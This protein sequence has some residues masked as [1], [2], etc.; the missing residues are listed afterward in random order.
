MNLLFWHPG[1][2]HVGDYFRCIQF[3]KYL[4]NRGHKVTCLLGR[5]KLSQWFGRETIDS[6]EFVYA[7]HWAELHVAESFIDAQPETKMPLDILCRTVWTLVNARHYDIVHSFHVGLSSLLPLVTA[8][9]F[10]RT[11][12]VQDWCDLWCD[13]ILQPPEQS[14]FARASYYLSCRVEDALMRRC[15][16]ITVNSRY[17][18]RKALKDYGHDPRYVL[19]VVEGADSDLITPQDKSACRQRLKL[20]PDLLWLGFSAFFNP[21]AELLLGT[22]QH[23]LRKRPGCY[24]LLWIGPTDRRIQEAIIRAGLNRVVEQVGIVPRGS[25]GTYLGACD[26]LLLPFSRQR[27]NYARWPAKLCDYLAAGRPIVGNATGEVEDFFQ[28]NPQIGVL[29]EGQPALFADAIIRLTENNEELQ[30]C[31]RAAR[32][33]AEGQISWS[34]ATNELEAFYRKLCGRSV[35]PM[36]APS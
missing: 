17:L 27:V 18:E 22:M 14:M 10:S 24:G 4:A 35:D 13:G 28:R 34:A 8:G 21:D 9:V 29:T 30:R 1:F 23:I 11:V 25:I 16:A 6:V 20:R 31:G 7:P 15:A 2:Y 33:V 19:R 32:A 26:L 12:C 5:R 3:A 36:T